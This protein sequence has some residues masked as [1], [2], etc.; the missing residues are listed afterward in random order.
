MN[1]Y[2]KQLLEDNKIEWQKTLFSKRDLD[3][4]IN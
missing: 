2:F 3:E 4:M 1:S